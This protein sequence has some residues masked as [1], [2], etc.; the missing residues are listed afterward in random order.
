MSPSVRKKHAPEG[1]IRAA[2][3][4]RGSKLW[5]PKIHGKDVPLNIAAEEIVTSVA[6]FLPSTLCVN[7]EFQFYC[8]RGAVQPFNYIVC[9]GIL[10]ETWGE[11]ERPPFVIVAGDD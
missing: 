11:H 3:K 5:N 10:V 6:T 4:E 1:M 2:W 8:A 7:L 9:E